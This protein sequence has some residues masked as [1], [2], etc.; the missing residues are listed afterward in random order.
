M[1]TLSEQALLRS[2]NLI[3]DRW[4][5]AGLGARLQVADPATGETFANVPDSDAGD[6]RLAVD[7]AA[8]A[9]PAWSRRPARERAQLL[10]R[11]HALILAHQEDLARIISTEQGSP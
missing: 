9:F 7:A 10:K 11:W 1:L 2:Q 6:A 8:A 3:D 5:D 4:C